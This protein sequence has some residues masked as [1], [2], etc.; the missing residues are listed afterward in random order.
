MFTRNE[1]DDNC[2]IHILMLSE[3]K[4]KANYYVEQAWGLLTRKF[5][6]AS[7]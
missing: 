6:V 1:N 2:K 7:E 3:K 4:Q 5:S